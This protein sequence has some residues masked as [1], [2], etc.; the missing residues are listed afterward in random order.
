MIDLVHPDALVIE[1]DAPEAEEA[2]IEVCTC[3]RARPP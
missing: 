1:S 2:A 3:G